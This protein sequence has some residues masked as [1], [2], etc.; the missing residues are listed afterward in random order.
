MP[1]AWV[2]DEQAHQGERA[3]E[4]EH[5]W[6]CVCGRKWLPLIP[7]T[8][9]MGTLEILHLYPTP[10]LSTSLLSCRQFTPGRNRRQVW[11]ASKPLETSPKYR[12]QV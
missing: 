1:S 10:A 9:Q 4:Y 2:R 12:P 8:K 3:S 5:G 11:P 7:S 6:V